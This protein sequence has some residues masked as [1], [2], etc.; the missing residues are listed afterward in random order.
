MAVSVTQLI[1]AFQA[2]LDHIWSLCLNIALLQNH[3][4][5]LFFKLQ[6]FNLLFWTQTCL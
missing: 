5:V 3:F 2:C 6:T 4:I 1:S